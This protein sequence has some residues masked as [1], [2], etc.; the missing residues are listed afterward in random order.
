MFQGLGIDFNPTT[1]AL[2]VSEDNGDSTGQ[3]DNF[4]VNPNT[5]VF[6]QQGDLGG[7]GTDV[8]IAAIAYTNNFPA[9][10]QTTLYALE[11]N[12]RQSSDSR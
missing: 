10:P 6:T 2:R 4:S 8:D 5:G 7:T 1:D 9:A 3:D 11:T 12:I